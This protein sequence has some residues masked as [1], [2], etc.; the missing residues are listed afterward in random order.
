MTILLQRQRTHTSELSEA[1]DGPSLTTRQ[2]LDHS[3][4]EREDGHGVVVV[5]SP[6]GRA[7]F[8]ARTCEL[9]KRR[10]RE[11]CLSLCTQDLPDGTRAFR[12]QARGD[13]AIR[14]SLGVRC[15]VSHRSLLAL[16]TRSNRLS[17]LAVCGRSSVR[18]MLLVV[19]C[20]AA[21]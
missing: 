5:I 18:L 20:F 15:P 11:R 16:K 19:L 4:A 7:S 8:V 10:C 21:L 12:R 17:E 3:S 2:A 14:I 13:T 9:L 6:Q 1:D